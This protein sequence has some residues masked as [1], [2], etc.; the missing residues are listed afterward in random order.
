MEL[1]V[2]SIQELV[3]VLPTPKAGVCE[4]TDV[5]LVRHGEISLENST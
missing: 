3:I 1:Q 4:L 2:S 5:L